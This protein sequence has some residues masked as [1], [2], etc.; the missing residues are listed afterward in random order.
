MLPKTWKNAD[1]S[2]DGRN[3]PAHVALSCIAWS[4]CWCG[5]KNRYVSMCRQEEERFVC[6]MM[7]VSTKYSS[8]SCTFIPQPTRR[9]ASCVCIYVQQTEYYSLR[10]S[11]ILNRLHLTRKALDIAQVI[12]LCPEKGAK[13]GGV[14]RESNSSSSSAAQIKKR[15]I[16]RFASCQGIM[17]PSFLRL[18]YVPM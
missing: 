14:G 3:G 7:H 1:I 13:R 18:L 5:G 17:K 6:R 11:S 15:A 16:E 2:S 12:S 4:R 9:R 10:D 8:T